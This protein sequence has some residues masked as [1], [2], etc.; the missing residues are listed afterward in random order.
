M[1]VEDLLGEFA[2]TVMGESEFGEENCAVKLCGYGA[3]A[4]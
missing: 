2:D 4:V 1:V 3:G